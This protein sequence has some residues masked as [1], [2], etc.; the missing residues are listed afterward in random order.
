MADTSQNRGC[1]QIRAEDPQG[2]T[3]RD[4]WVDLPG[5]AYR[6]ARNHPHVSVE[7][8]VARLHQTEARGPLTAAQQALPVRSSWIRCTAPPVTVSA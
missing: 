7:P 5:P 3:T 1:R 8:G 6:S 4:V 2:G